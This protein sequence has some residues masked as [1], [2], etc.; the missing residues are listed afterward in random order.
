MTRKIDL[1]VKKSFSDI[2]L[3]DLYF[4]QKFPVM[5]K[6]LIKCNLN[7]MKLKSYTILMIRKKGINDN[8]LHYF[9]NYKMKEMFHSL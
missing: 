9:D 2:T 3:D 1:L 5:V 4:Y 8:S 6:F 7:L